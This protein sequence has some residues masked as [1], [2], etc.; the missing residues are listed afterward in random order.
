MDQAPF[1][2]Q[3]G[4]GTARPYTAKD[5]LGAHAIDQQGAAAFQNLLRPISHVAGQNLEN[6]NLS[7][8]H[9][10][11]YWAARVWNSQ[12]PSIGH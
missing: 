8:S 10:A 4:Y 6:H 9:N 3:Y 11:W 2:S 7:I 5:C 12:A 1:V